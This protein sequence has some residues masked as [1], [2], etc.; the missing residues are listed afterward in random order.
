[1]AKFPDGVPIP[2]DAVRLIFGRGTRA[3]MYPLNS[4]EC[5]WFTCLPTPQV[6]LP[7]VCLH[8]GEFVAV[9]RDCDEC[10]KSLVY[11]I[12]VDRLLT[13]MLRELS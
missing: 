6:G 11:V 10:G 1:M 4:T 2:T 9:I 7:F 5:Y 3:G 13:Y 8:Q 12:G